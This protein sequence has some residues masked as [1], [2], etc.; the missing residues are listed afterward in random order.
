MDLTEAERTA[1]AEIP[2]DA[3]AH[4]QA[5]GIPE[6]FGE[7]GYTNRERNWARPTLDFNGIYGGFQGEGSKTVIPSY[8]HAKITCRLVANQDPNKIQDL[9]EAHVIKHMPPG[10]TVEVQK[11]PGSSPTYY[12]S[13][14][15]PMNKVVGEVLTEVFEVSPY[16]ARVGGSIPI[17]SHF[18]NYLGANTFNF[19]WSCADENLHAPNEF[20]RLQNF[21]RGQKAYCMLLERL[22]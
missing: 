16:L 3:E 11:K 17:V 4:R 12:V 14:D 10:V 21:E 13:P 5:L 19:G 22:G 20:F 9:I 18:Q 2:Y 15:H 6:F 1:F 7:P 8:A